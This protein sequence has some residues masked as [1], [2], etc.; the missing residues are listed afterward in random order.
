MS[1]NE[2]IQSFFTFRYDVQTVYHLADKYSDMKAD[3][4]DNS[5]ALAANNSKPSFADALNSVNLPP[6]PAPEKPKAKRKP[7]KVAILNY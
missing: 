4:V 5:A 6:V 1:A 7:S 3:P 2:V